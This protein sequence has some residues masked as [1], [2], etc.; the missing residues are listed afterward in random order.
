MITLVGIKTESDGGIPR[1]DKLMIGTS[2][3]NNLSV[4][5]LSNL[6]VIGV[7]PECHIQ[8][9]VGNNRKNG[10]CKR[11]LIHCPIVWDT[12]KGETADIAPRCCRHRIGQFIPFLHSSSTIG[13][14]PPGS[15]R[16]RAALCGID[17]ERIKGIRRIHPDQKI[18][19][20]QSPS[21]TGRVRDSHVLRRRRDIAL[22][23]QPRLVVGAH[24]SILQP[25]KLIRRCKGVIKAVPYNKRFRRVLFIWHDVAETDLYRILGRILKTR[26][27]QILSILAATVLK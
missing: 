6:N 13:G 11:S 23:H 26:T 24:H 15:N 3:R 17:R 10:R 18:I 9:M 12:I 20:R 7:M 19:Y 8:H 2:V 25:H 14:S 5:R 16:N 21:A 4:L 22:V 1:N 27:H